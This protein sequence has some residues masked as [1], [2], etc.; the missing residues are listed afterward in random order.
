MEA[1]PVSLAKSPG[2]R[3]IPEPIIAFT[4]RH[5]VSKT[6][7]PFDGDAGDM[8]VPFYLLNE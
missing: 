5:R 1:G 3:K 6:E 4:P 8:I 7:S 2:K